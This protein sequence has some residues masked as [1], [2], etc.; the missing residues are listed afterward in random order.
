M[1]EFGKLA[2]T[3]CSDSFIVRV[4]ISLPSDE[5]KPRAAMCE[6]GKGLEEWR[7][8][9]E[10]GKGG[11]REGSRMDGNNDDRRNLKVGEGRVEVLERSYDME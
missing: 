9:K 3:R 1:E 7:G 4:A 5:S 10:W 6:E 8:R 2:P 11:N